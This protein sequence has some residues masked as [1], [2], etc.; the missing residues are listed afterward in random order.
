LRFSDARISQ[1]PGSEAQASQ[2]AHGG[3]S[4]LEVSGLMGRLGGA[5]FLRDVIFRGQG[6]LSRRSRLEVQVGGPSHL[7]SIGGPDRPAAGVN[8][9]RLDGR[10][11]DP[12]R[13]EA[14]AI[15][16]APRWISTELAPEA[17][18]VPPGSPGLVRTRQCYVAT[19]GGMK[20]CAPSSPS[21]GEGW[22]CRR[23]LL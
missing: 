18:R 12:F 6:R 8:V 14:S 5:R 15:T 4:S 20:P 13:V 9:D 22:R 23:S 1:I 2:S 16:R 10:R 11:S 21:Y 3:A 17:P 19:W 7:R